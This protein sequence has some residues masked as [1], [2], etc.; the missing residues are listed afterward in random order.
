MKKF[1]NEFRE[2][3]SRGNV[4]DMAVGMMLGTAF[5][6][7]V[8]SLVENVLS[9]LVALFTEGMDLSDWVIELGSAKLGI[10]EVINSVVSFL[11]TALVL[12]WVIK[13]VNKLKRMSH[14]KKMKE[15]E[16]KASAQAKEKEEA[17]KAAA[18]EK[19][20]KIE[21][22][23]KAKEEADRLRVEEVE[24]LREIRNSLNK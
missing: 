12:F 4:I 3:I 20:K 24:L 18:E 7:I 16:E 19:A 9:P 1:S 22:A 2:F 14:K 15:E 11:L 5:N 6:G 8:S 10:G 17:E 13:G 21:A 23:K